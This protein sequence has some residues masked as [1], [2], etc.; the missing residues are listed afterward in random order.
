MNPKREVFLRCLFPFL[1]VNLSISPLVS[2]GEEL[3]E[4]KA[5]EMVIQL[6]SL[7]ELIKAV[8]G[9]LKPVLHKAEAHKHTYCVIDGLTR[10]EYIS[11]V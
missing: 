10:C 7:D 8:D 5:R 3:P 2:R 11:G 4:A 1:V 6:S 9:L